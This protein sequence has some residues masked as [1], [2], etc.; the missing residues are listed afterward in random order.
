M[1]DIKAFILGA[2]FSHSYS[3]NHFPLTE[4]LLPIVINQALHSEEARYQELIQFIGEHFDL[5]PLENESIDFSDPATRINFESVASF[6]LNRPFPSIGEPTHTYDLLYQQLLTIISRSLGPLDIEAV[7]RDK[8]TRGILR[9]FSRYLMSTP[10]LVISFNYDLILDHYLWQQ[11]WKPIR[12]YGVQFLTPLTQTPIRFSKDDKTVRF[13]K[14]HGSLNWGIFPE[15]VMDLGNA[16]IQFLTEKPLDPIDTVHFRGRFLDQYRL[17]PYLVPPVVG[18]TYQHRQIRLLWHEARAALA[19]AQEIYIIGY[20]LPPSDVTA[21][22]LFRAGSAPAILPDSSKTIT[23][24][25]PGLDSNQQERFQEAFQTKRYGH[26]IRFEKR[27]AM[28][29]LSELLKR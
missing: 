5:T 11:G 26:S 25:D 3:P 27:D 19:V 14:L 12:G 10:S 4:R 16:S 6:L 13:L 24:V 2:G 28:Q 29:Y 7:S 1:S 20:S 8:W 9:D 15:D 23:V 22:F 17:Y 18:K 21:E